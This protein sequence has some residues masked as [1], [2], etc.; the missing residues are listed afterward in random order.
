MPLH[1]LAEDF[2]FRQ[3][4][5]EESTVMEQNLKCLLLNS[6]K[7]SGDFQPLIDLDIG[8]ADFTVDKLH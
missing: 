2:E 4:R 6:F 8:F 5:I 3:R 1:P 7:V